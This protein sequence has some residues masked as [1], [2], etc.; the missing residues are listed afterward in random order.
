MSAV[1]IGPISQ[2]WHSWLQFSR[3]DYLKYGCNVCWVCLLPFKKY[4]RSFFGDV[5]DQNEL[6]D[7]LNH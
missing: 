6:V 5:T 1:T 4:F 7:A 2:C 3:V